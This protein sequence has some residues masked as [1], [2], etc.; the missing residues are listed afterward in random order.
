MITCQTIL[1]ALFHSFLRDT[2]TT[3]S[4]IPVDYCQKIKHEFLKQSLRYKLIST[5]NETSNELLE[6]AKS[7]S[8]KNFMNFIKND[9]V[10]G[11]SYT[12]DLLICH[13]CKRT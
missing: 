12:C 3:I 7:L 5:I 6:L 2:N 9:I 13:V 11:Y 10:T 1:K 8:Q 4:E